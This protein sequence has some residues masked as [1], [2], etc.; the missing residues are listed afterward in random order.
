MDNNSFVNTFLLL[1]RTGVGKSKLAKILSGDES[2]KVG[3]TFLPET[4]IPKCYNCEYNYEKECFKY[5]IID[6]PGYDDLNGN[7]KTIFRHIDNFLTSRVYKIKGIVLLYSFQDPKFGNNHLEGLKKIL[8]LFPINN[9]WDYVIIIF[10]RTYTDGE[11]D[12]EEK[13][14][15]LKNNLKEIFSDLISRAARDLKIDEAN[16]DN[17][18]IKF[19]NLI[20]KTNKNGLEDII[21]TFRKNVKLDPLFHKITISTNVKNIIE[22]KEKDSTIGQLYKVKFK[23]Y[24]Y[25]NQKDELIKTLEKPIAKDPIREVKDLKLIEKF[26]ACGSIAYNGVLIVGISAAMIMCPLLLFQGVSREI[27]NCYDNITNQINSFNEFNE[28]KIIGQLD[29]LVE[30]N[31]E[32]DENN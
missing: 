26:K 18:K 2:I 14:I 5:S 10:T 11:E 9:F 3:D 17:I 12:D 29:P 24:N 15:K 1:G 19:V 16:F 4:K 28:Q 20:S 23:I 27:F 30:E 8:Q 21:S 7:D 22:I 13:K 32:N 6:T 31:A 25:Y